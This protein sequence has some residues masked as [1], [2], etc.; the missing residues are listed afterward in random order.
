M[1]PI[2]LTQR[3]RPWADVMTAH[4][5]I[6]LEGKRFGRL[7][8]MKRSRAVG[9]NIQW[10]WTCQCDCGR[11]V[12]LY[13][14][15]VRR[16]LSKSCGCLRRELTAA[17]RRTHGASRTVEHTTW[18]QMIGRCA[19]PSNVRFADYGGRGIRVCQRWSESF[20]AFLEDMGPR[21]GRHT[22]ERID[23]NG[24]YEPGN[25]RWATWSE[26]AS[27]KRSN[28]MLEHEGKSMTLAQW[29]RETGLQRGCIAARIQRG[30]SVSRALT[31]GL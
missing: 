7:V 21:P 26:Q 8:V 2:L 11:T 3:S 10:K 27:N 6:D 17:K 24:N 13:G 9:K 19:N 25:C 28:R 30:W 5:A 12:E 15:N 23:N 4:N 16:G 18:C 29:S 1:G 22:I 14:N 31:E 20:A